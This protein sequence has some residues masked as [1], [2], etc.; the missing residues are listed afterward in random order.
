MSWNEHMEMAQITLV[1]SDTPLSLH[2]FIEYLG[3]FREAYAV[4][5]R[6]RNLS[7]QEIPD[8][9][10]TLVE[11]VHDIFSASYQDFNALKPYD[12]LNFVPGEDE[13]QLLEITKSSPMELLLGGSLMLLIFAVVL[14]GGEISYENGKLRCKV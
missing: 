1:E 5:T 9:Q 10:E 11:V 8:E 2:A 4:G 13:L 12:F 14:S 3:L 7:I 6:F